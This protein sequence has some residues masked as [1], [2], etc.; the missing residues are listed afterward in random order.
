M[1]ANTQT[2]FY[3]KSTKC[4]CCRETVS[5]FFLPDMTSH[6]YYPKEKEG[7]Q[8]VSRWEWK[9]PNLSYINPYYY[10]IIICPKC[11]YADFRDDFL[12]TEQLQTNKVNVLREKIL[13]EKKKK[14]SLIS[15]IAEKIPAEERNFEQAVFLHLLAIAE[16]ELLPGPGPQENPRSNRDWKKLGR[17][18]LRAAWL[19]REKK[20]GQGEQAGQTGVL[21]SIKGTIDHMQKSIS[22]FQATLDNL[23][24]LNQTQQ[25]FDNEHK[26]YKKDVFL[27]YQACILRINGLLNQ[28][29]D[30]GINLKKA[31]DVH[32]QLFKGKEG[33]SIESEV[34]HQTLS[35]FSSLWTGIPVDEAEC[36]RRSAEY[37]HLAADNDRHMSDV[38]GLKLMELALKILLESRQKKEAEEIYKLFIK[39]GSD[40]RSSLMKKKFQQH[41]VEEDANITSEMNKVNTILQDVSFFYKSSAQ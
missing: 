21:P 15:L 24:A 39:R 12:G 22:E 28:I 8:H 37:F 2:P 20:P 34:L 30:T 6:L 1:A 16:Q 25:K 13:E 29:K 38:E 27:I 26:L 7:D 33:L 5:I 14:D 31:N 36:I 10:D 41:S 35:G 19:F 4:P 23:S 3:L 40:L 18:Y 9:S 32:V 11:S 17:L